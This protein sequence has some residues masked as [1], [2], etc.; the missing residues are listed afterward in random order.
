MNTRLKVTL[1]IIAVFYACNLFAQ[2]AERKFIAINNT[3]I[4]YK[5]FNLDSRKKGEPIVIFEGGLGSGAGNFESIFPFLPQNITS[6]VYDRNGIGE[7]EVDDSIKTDADVIRRLHTLLDTLKIS[8]PYLLV[9]HSLGGPFIRLYA[10]MYPDEV[11]G[12]VF[13]DPTNFM[14]KKNEDEQVKKKSSSTT[15]Y[16]DIWKINLNSMSNDTSL[17]IGMRNEAKRELSESTPHFFKNYTS[18]APLKDIPVTILISYNK[19]TEP[20]EKKMNEDMKLGLNLVSWWKELDML[21]IEH[22]TDM[23]KNNHNSSI[24]LLPLYSHGIHNQ[25]PK[26]VADAIS[27]TYDNCLKVLKK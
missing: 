4:A 20:F 23:I 16:I 9:G 2:K 1:I 22:Y 6:F 10:S 21:R 5:T 19:P 11:C 8:P 18:L 7:S 26:L 3:K 12:L 24:I 14:L 25:D 17:P 13:I 15:G 27:N